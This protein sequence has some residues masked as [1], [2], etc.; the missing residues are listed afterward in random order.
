[1]IFR[2]CIDF[3]FSKFLA[4]FVSSWNSA[5]QT[6]LLL[7]RPCFFFIIHA[8]FVS[9]WNSAN[10]TL[11]LLC[12][13]CFFFVIHAAA[14]SSSSFSHTTSSICFFSSSFLSASLYISLLL[15]FLC[16]QVTSLN[17]KLNFSH[18]RNLNLYT[19]ALN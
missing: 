5:D 14:S 16:T 19:M 4:G 18:S 13:L 8:G 17:L 2:A 12:R 6:L 15:L 11:L 7:C 10:Q 9:S 1:M 3:G